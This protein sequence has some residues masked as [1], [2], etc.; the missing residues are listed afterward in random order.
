M[1]AYLQRRSDSKIR[2]LLSLK[3]RHVL[4][5]FGPPKGF[6]RAL[7]KG[8]EWLL[9]L[10]RCTFIFDS[11]IM[12][13]LAFHMFHNCV[14]DR[15]GEITRLSNY[16]MK[17][18]RPSRDMKQPPCIHINVRIDGWIFEVMFTY[19]AISKVKETIHKFYEIA[20]AMEPDQ[21]LLPVF[22][23]PGDDV[24]PI[25]GSALNVARRGKAQPK[26]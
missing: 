23:P 21:L 10:N 16:F 17:E 1:K 25:A 22:E 26:P 8:A 7:E 14:K 18:G 19:T 5:K 2:T 9:D 20:R 15:G 13:V 4:V 3:D 11:P 24:P 6:A 12:L